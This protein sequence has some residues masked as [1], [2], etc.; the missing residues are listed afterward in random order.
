MVMYEVHSHPVHQKYKS[1]I[2]SK[3]TL[4]QFFV[5][6]LTFIPPLI[7]AFVTHGFWLKE[8]FYREQPDVRFKHEILLV[9]QGNIPGSFLAYSTFQN[10]NQLLQ[11]KFRIPL[12]KSWENDDNLDGKY[13]SL[14]FNIEIPLRDS[15]AIHSVQLLLIFDYQLQKYVSL[16]MESIAYIY[17]SSPLA[18][19]EF[20]TSGKLRLQQS[21]PLPHKGVHAIY[22]ISVIDVST[23][24]VSSYPLWTGGRAAGQ[25]FV[26]K[27]TVFYP[28]E[29]IMYR[30]GFWQLIKMAWIQYLSVLFIFLF[31]FRRVKR[32]V[33]EN[34]V[35]TV[36]PMRIEKEHQD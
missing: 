10:F 3:A 18:G 12:I 16:Q 11:Q 21:M 2:C 14:H 34:Q 4:L 13:D 25:P 26:L 1:H 22:N 36:V 15:E 7:I 32:F 33:F 5:I 8:S 24:Y 29:T 23:E 30:P 28:E 19:A 9:L 17:H 27:G 31:V 6:I 35:V 20:S